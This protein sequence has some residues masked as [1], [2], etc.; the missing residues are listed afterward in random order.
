MCVY[1][2]VF[3]APVHTS[4][5]VDCVFFSKDG[6][7][8]ELVDEMNSGRVLYALIRVKDPN[9]QLLKNVWINWVSDLFL[10]AV[11]SSLDLFSITHIYFYH[12]VLG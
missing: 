4:I 6:E 9:T 1:V 2:C 7:I 5:Y 8:D 10:I 12:T 3:N 11:G